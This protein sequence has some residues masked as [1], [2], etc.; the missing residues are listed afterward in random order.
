MTHSVTFGSVFRCR[1]LQTNTSQGESKNKLRNMK[2]SEK[3]ASTHDATYRDCVLWL[4]CSLS[5]YDNVHLLSCTVSLLSPESWQINKTFS[6]V[7]YRQR[8]IIACLLLVAQ[9]SLTK[10]V[11]KV[12]P[13]PPA[14]KITDE[15]LSQCHETVSVSEVKIQWHKYKGINKQKWSF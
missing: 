7:L 5:M 4:R 11:R 15:P 14:G 12:S 2:V 13:T 8:L 1:A 6:T 9:T 3:I 10:M